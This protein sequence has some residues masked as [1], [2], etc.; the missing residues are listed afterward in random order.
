M[1]YPCVKQIDATDCAA[2]CLS[3]ICKYYNKNISISTIRK[4]ACTDKDGTNGIGLIQAAK[5]IGIDCEGYEIEDKNIEKNSINCPFIAHVVMRGFN[6][7]VVIFEYGMESVIIADPADGLK[8]YSLEEFKTFWTGIIFTVE[9]NN[10][11]ET[12]K[13]EKTSFCKMLSLINT[14]RK[15]LIILF[16]LS[17]M[18]MLIGIATS[19]FFNALFDDIVPNENINKLKYATLC[20]ACLSF[21]QKFFHYIR[22][23]V[24][25]NFERRLDKKITLNTFKHILRLPLSFFSMRQ[26]GEII[27]RLNDS[28]KI[29]AALSGTS[30]SV[31]IDTIMAFVCGAFLFYIDSRMFLLTVFIV[32]LILFLIVCL[33]LK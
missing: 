6:H 8:T 22:V 3:T 2:A 31:F 33:F 4:Y 14:E 19:M 30:V 13:N 28:Y 20:F 1:K 12:L 18:Y 7:Y 25:I 9:I 32:I 15:T 11:F 21:F 29:R 17:T 5:K 27:S 10:E 24:I 16:F 23:R 26:T